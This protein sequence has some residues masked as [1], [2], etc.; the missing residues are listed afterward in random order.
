VQA[1]IG[2]RMLNGDNYDDDDQSEF[3]QKSALVFP[4]LMKPTLEVEDANSYRPI[5]T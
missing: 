3:E 2:Q 4:R 5:S 1:W